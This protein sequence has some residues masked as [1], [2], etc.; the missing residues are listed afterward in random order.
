MI[1]QELDLKFIKVENVEEFRSLECV[2]REKPR[3][4]IFF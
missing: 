2:R 3:R 1:I 4:I